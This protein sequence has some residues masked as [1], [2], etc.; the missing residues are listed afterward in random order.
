[1]KQ[2]KLTTPDTKKNLYYGKTLAINLIIIG[3]IY[4]FTIYTFHLK[5]SATLLLIGFVILLMENEKDVDY[6]ITSAQIILIVIL[7]IF[8][9][10]LVTIDVN[11]DI[12]YILIVT[13]IVA[14]KEFLEKYLSSYQ[15]KR[16]NFL[17]YIL[18]IPVVI[19]FVQRIINI[20]SMYQ[21]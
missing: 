13:S 4:F 8:I 1:M 21:G 20:L 15:Q 2:P 10:W 11:F 12:F 16:M 17:F 3:F 19:I 9:V 7:L 6:T 14:L 18:L 5:L